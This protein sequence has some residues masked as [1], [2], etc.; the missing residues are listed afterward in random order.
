M[1]S[2]R[3]FPL[4]DADSFKSGLLNWAATLG[5]FCWLDSNGHTDPLGR[6]DGLM[7]I[8]KA[9][10]L[11][12]SARG[13]FEALRAFREQTGD[14]VLGYLGYD[15]KNDLEELESGNPDR[16]KF[17]DLIVFQPEKII[18]I[19]RGQA[20]FR[21]LPRAVGEIESDRKAIADTPRELTDAPNRQL[22]TRMGIFKEAYFRAAA[23]LLAAIHRGDFYE[24][25]FCQEF[26][27]EEAH[28][29]VAA[30]YR[31]LN[32]ISRAPFAAWMQFGSRSI[33]SASPERYLCKRGAT[34][35]SQ[36]MKGTARRDPSP[37]TD[38]QLALN[39]QADPKERA[40]N[41]MIADLVRN[42]LSRSALRGSVRVDGLCELRTYEQVHQLISTIR[43]KVPGE[44]DPVQL[45]QDTFPMGSMTGA[46]KI[47]AMQH[48][49]SR[50]SF[51]RGAYSG[52]LGYMTP[53][54]DFDF[55]VLIRS[56]FYD[57]SRGVASFPVGGA[58]TAA[59]TP[60]AEYEE[61]LL[62]AR[63]MRQVLEGD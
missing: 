46:P 12:S 47:S 35:W 10:E 2:E 16:M 25:T 52:A 32:A 57:A 30:T 49:E 4:D 62:K 29:D 42:D 22:R 63:A 27:V 28:L 7:G 33:L 37:E 31:R 45:L 18:E 60:E 48:I 11:Q 40:E 9:A 13:A 21:Y 56:L 15:L 59:A 53:D 44:I 20:V 24:V 58:L 8:G 14:W 17:P 38:R 1:R 3:R 61:C 43:A 50:E 39:L 51:K 26:F 19:R 23:K 34:V 55:N 41:I 5:D 36:P 54:G 6:F